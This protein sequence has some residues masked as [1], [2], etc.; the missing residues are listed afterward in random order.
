M[1]IKWTGNKQRLHCKTSILEWY[2]P[3]DL[4]FKLEV[5]VGEGKLVSLTNRE[6]RGG[7]VYSQTQV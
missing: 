3:S 6:I 2:L 7:V 4:S 1:V 5:R